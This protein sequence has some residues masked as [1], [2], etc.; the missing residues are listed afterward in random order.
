MAMEL[1]NDDI[2]KKEYVYE[3]VTIISQ[4][5]KLKLK[6]VLNSLDSNGFLF[7]SSGSMGKQFIPN[8]IFTKIINNLRMYQERALATTFISVTLGLE[9]NDQEFVLMKFVVN[10]EVVSSTEIIEQIQSFFKSGN[11]DMEWKY[12][13]KKWFNLINNPSKN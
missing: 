9:E 3:L 10:F 5:Q 13:L 4:D 12:K 8:H 1:I 6:D 11:I 7:S 2:F